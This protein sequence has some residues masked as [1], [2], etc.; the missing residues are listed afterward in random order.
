MEG[1]VHIAAADVAQHGLQ[2]REV[3]VNVGDQRVAHASRPRGRRREVGG[4]V[5]R[6]RGLVCNR[7][8]PQF[9]CEAFELLDRQRQQEID[10]ATEVV[11]RVTEG[12][13]SHFVRAND[14]RGVGHAPVRDSRLAGERRARLPR[15]ITDG[16]EHVG[17][18]AA[19]NA[20]LREAHCRRATTSNRSRFPPTSTSVLGPSLSSPGLGVPVPSSV[21]TIESS[22]ALR[23]VAASNAALVRTATSR[24][25]R[26]SR[27]Q[28]RSH[29]NARGL[30]RH[31]AHSG[32][33]SSWR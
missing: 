32:C 21:T 8:H 14:R 20:G 11:H 17:D 30:R 28:K 1:R 19:S 12:L 10:A 24:V 16:E 3:G 25:S 9:E 27:R 7:P 26:C 2:R 29:A 18:A 5:R 31:F 13:A 15:L 22:C 6:G 23:G 33:C 4:S